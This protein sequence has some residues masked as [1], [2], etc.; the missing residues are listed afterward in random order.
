LFLG[1]L[2]MLFSFFVFIEVFFEFLIEVIFLI[3]RSDL[4]LEVFADC[5]RMVFHGIEFILLEFINVSIDIVLNIVRP[6][7]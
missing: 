7:V 2:V 4:L 5:W 1:L 6:F 3:L